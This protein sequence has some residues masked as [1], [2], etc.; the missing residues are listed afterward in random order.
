MTTPEQQRKLRIEIPGLPPRELSP[1]ARVHWAVKAKAAR[2]YGS[3]VFYAAVD[4]R[5]RS[6]P[7]KWKNLDRAKVRVWFY[8]PPRRRR[9][10]DNLIASFKPGLDALVR[11]GILVDDSI[12]HVEVSHTATQPFDGKTPSTTV[13]VEA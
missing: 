4:A 13:E 12:G 6:E 8:V 11:C 1:N 9:D 7:A 10:L 5:N 3:Q 2:E